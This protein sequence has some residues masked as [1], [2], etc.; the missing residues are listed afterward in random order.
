MNAIERLINALSE[1]LDESSQS[2][3]V[4]TVNRKALAELIRLLEADR[5]V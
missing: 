1:E 3:P 5:N 2:I 4:V